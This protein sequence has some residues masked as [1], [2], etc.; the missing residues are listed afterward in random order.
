ML[1]QGADEKSKFELKDSDRVVFLG[2]TFMEREARDG[3]GKVEVAR[4]FVVAELAFAFSASRS[5]FST[6]VDGTPTIAL[7]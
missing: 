4:V 5:V 1:A 6:L 7:R 3:D 2:G